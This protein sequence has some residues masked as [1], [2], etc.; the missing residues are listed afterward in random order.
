MHLVPLEPH[1]W[2]SAGSASSRTRGT[3]SSSPTTI[4]D[5]SSLALASS[6]KPVSRHLAGRLAAPR[7]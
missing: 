3:S 1:V 7:S 6:D 4:R 2:L 5:S